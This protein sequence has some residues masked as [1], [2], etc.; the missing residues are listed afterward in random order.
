MPEIDIAVHAAL[1]IEE[2]FVEEQE[3][4]DTGVVGANQSDADLDDVSVND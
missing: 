3:E 1:M 4:E 2:Q